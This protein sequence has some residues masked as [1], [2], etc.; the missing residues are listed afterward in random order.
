MKTTSSKTFEPTSLRR[1]VS[2]SSRA[3]RVAVGAGLAAGA[4]FAAMTGISAA[5]ATSGTTGGSGSTTAPA[6]GPGPLGLRGGPGGLGGPRGPG[7]PGGGGTITAINGSTLTL[8]TENGTETVDTSSSTTYSKEMQSIA[9]SDL[10]VN[11]VVH[12]ASTPPSTPPT[13]SKTTPTEPGTGTVKATAVTVVEP[14]FTGR[15]QSVSNGTYTLVGRD[16]QLLTVGTTG[17]TR[18]YKGT[19]KASS[20][21]ISVGAHVMAEGTQNDL[22]HLS[23]DVIAVMPTPPTPSTPPA[24]APALPTR[25]GGTAS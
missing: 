9:F 20:S 2:R 11:D 16:G 19:S 14:S 7:G 18:Y 3:A 4:S 5:A 24:G 25:P 17:S 22:T 1:L 15:V 10:H 8:R 23:A 21:A 13:A 6:P 12:V